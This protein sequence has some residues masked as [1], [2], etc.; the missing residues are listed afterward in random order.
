[1]F[2]SFVQ[3]LYKSS[4][5]WYNQQLAPPAAQADYA[6]QLSLMFVPMLNSK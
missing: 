5:W 2:F 1:M 3:A 6:E 4:Q